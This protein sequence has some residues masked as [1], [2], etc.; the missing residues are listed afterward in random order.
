MFTRHRPAFTPTGR[1]RVVLPASLLTLTLATGCSGG[2]GGEGDGESYPTQPVSFSVGSEPGSGWDATAR[3]IVQVM[4]EEDLTDTNITVQ[5]Q[6]G[7]VGCVLLNRMVTDYEGEA[8]EIAMTSTPLFSNELRGQCDVNYKDITLIARLMT[9][10]FL[11]T[12]PVDS[13]YADLEALLA[14][15]TE[16][17]QSVPIAASGDDQLPFALLVQAAGGDPAAVNFVEFES[18]GEYLTAMLNGDVVASVS[19]VTE[20]GAQIEA[21]ELQG[22]AILRDE[23]LEAPYDDIPTAKE[24]G[25]DVTLSNWRGVYG[26]P[27]MPEEAVTYWQDKLQ[28]IMETETWKEIAERNQWEITYADG[29]ELAEFL[30]EEYAQIEEALNSVGA[31]G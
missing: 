9:E 2:F 26:P 1:V 29:E 16:D 19:G 23:R 12:A 22:L 18:G 7:S 24:L 17:P 21:G 13:P 10:N 8:H 28:E 3:A 20:F 14:A 6:P 25:Y 11:V 27:G 31:T 4:E 15:V 5:N 30:D